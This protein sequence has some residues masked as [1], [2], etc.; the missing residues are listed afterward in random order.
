MVTPPLWLA[1]TITNAHRPARRA[2]FFTDS[3]TDVYLYVYMSV[4]LAVFT[5]IVMDGR[6]DGSCKPPVLDVVISW[7]DR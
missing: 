1:S 2:A 6:G 5:Y 4:Y 7:N 3:F